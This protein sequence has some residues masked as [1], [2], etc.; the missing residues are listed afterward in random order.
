MRIFVFTVIAL[1]NIIFQSTLLNLFPIL[2]TLPNISFVIVVIYTILR[3]QEEGITFGFFVGLL[4]SI[5]FD[6]FLGYYSLIYMI[7]AYISGKTFLHYYKK[8]ILPA[9]IDVFALTFVYQI[10]MYITM[11]FFRGN[12]NFGYYFFNIMF[13]ESVYNVLYVLIIYYPIYFIN[14]AIE[15]HEK[16]KRNVFKI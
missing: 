8:N 15:K 3:N 2:S 14:K 9:V 4:Q 10:F 13:T 11:F 5:V 6:D 7:V 12:L 16:P 1:I